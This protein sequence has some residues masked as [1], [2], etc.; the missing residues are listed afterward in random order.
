MPLSRRSPALLT[1][2]TLVLLGSGAPA[3]D[4]PAFRTGVNFV[5]VD[6]FATLNGAPVHDLTANDFE[7]SEDGAPQSVE[8]FERVEAR[9]R[10]FVLFLDTYHVDLGGSRRLQKTLLTL[11]ERVVGPDDTYAVM[12]PEMSAADLTLTQRTSTIE[13][14]LSETG[15]GA[16]ASSCTRRIRSSRSTRSATP[17]TRR[18]AAR[19]RPAPPR[20]PTASTR[21]SRWRSSRGATRSAR[22]PRSRICRGISR[23]SARNARRFSWSPMGG[24][25]IALI[26]RCCASGRAISREARRAHAALGI[27]GTRG[28]SAPCRSCTG[29]HLRHGST[30]HWRLSTTGRPSRE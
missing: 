3:A 19:R 9:G 7:V 15:S 1:A 25:S 8:T 22:S 26:N 18:N 12:T 11:L 21:A 4:Q 29:A 28:S 14:Y 6:A 23:A 2:L 5:R 16:T 20:S 10:L 30:G 13:G 27:R 17:S 24:R